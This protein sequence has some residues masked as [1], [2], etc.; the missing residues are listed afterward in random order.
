M[1]MPE[2][3][4]YI[5]YR[6]NSTWSLRGWMAMRKTGAP[7]NEVMIRYRRADDKARIVA[8]SPT[9]KVPLLVHRRNGGEVKVWDSLAIGEYLAELFPDK[10]LWPADPE[11]RAFARSIA[12]EMHS[13][14]RELREHLPME[15]LERHPGVGLNHPGA[16]ADI[17]RV[18]EIWREARERWGR[19]AGGPFLFGNFTVADAM[20][21]P[22]VTRFRTYGADVDALCQDYMQAI[23]DDPDFRAWEAQAEID[24][25]PEPRSE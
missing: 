3:Q 16:A 7:F 1:P 13:G 23:L 25:P 9:G 14:F 2:F 8:A 4:L 18:G 10:R 11:A 17:N 21:T 12:A 24:P 22:V 5:G 19:K 15:L 20:Y 6:T